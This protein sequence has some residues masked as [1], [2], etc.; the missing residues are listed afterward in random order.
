MLVDANWN[1]RPDSVR[2]QTINI[3]IHTSKQRCDAF[4]AEMA[5]ICRFSGSPC[6]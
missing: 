1:M 5:M 3:A 4:L 6:L 2:H